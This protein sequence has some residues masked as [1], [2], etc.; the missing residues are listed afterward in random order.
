MEIVLC[1]DN[2]Y[3]M[4]AGIMMTSVSINNEDVNY[5]VIISADFSWEN[6]NLLQETAA[7][8]NNGIF[9]YRV[10]EEWNKYFPMGNKDM[11]ARITICAYY[12]LI[13]PKIL[14]DNIH[15]VLYLDCDMIIRK[16]LET[17]WNTNIDNIAIGA[18]HDMSE[19]KLTEIGY[20]PYPMALGYF[21]SGMLLVNLDYWREHNIVDKF[22]EFMTRNRE[23]IR[24]HDQDVLNAVLYD[25]MKW[26]PLT[27]NFQSGFLF[28]VNGMANI[29]DFL[30][31]EILNTEK[32]PAIIHFSISPKPWKPT[33]I[34][35]QRFVWE[36]YK[37]KSIW[38]NVKIP[39]SLTLREKLSWFLR[40]NNFWYL[41]YGLHRNIYRRV[42]LKK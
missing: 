23:I 16:S 39:S 33:C 17:L 1:T 26:L 24:Y 30:K 19:K 25:C 8:F 22:I 5:H 31:K 9:F 6:Q 34:H 27:Y 21:N 15:R 35:P 38:K 40:K 13:M 42:I 2:N 32:D 28:N 29:P 18:V 36:Y 37:K 3:V 11:A 7:R 20:L 10:G 41:K 14:P 4:P 12:R